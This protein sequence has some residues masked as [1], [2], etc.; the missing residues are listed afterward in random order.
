MYIIKSANKSLFSYSLCVSYP[1]LLSGV[2]ARGWGVSISSAKLPVCKPHC[3]LQA[4]A[5]AVVRGGG[6]E[7]ISMPYF[8]WVVDNSLRGASCHAGVVW[9][10]DGGNIYSCHILLHMPQAYGEVGGIEL[11]KKYPHLSVWITF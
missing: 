3:G 2:G 4:A 10:R 6:W 8:R 9:G 11:Q 5:I 7:Y 1:F